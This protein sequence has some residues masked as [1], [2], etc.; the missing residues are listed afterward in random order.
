ML[1]VQLKS[2]RQLSALLLLSHGCAAL[3]VLFVPLPLWLRF[4]LLGA[5]LLNLLY[6]LANQAWR[7]LPFSV[8]ALEFEREGGARMLL[9]SGKMLEARVLGSSFVAPYLT[10]ILLKTKRAWF[11]RG[12]VLLPDMLAPDLFRTLRVW[13]KWR[14]GRGDAPAANVDWMGS[15]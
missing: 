5:L 2:S 9:R 3:C 10:I 11:A 7:V 15:S 1:R 8:V 6:A 12:V 13:L 4:M 14:L